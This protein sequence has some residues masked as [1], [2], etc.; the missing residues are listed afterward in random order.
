[1]WDGAG[2]GGSGDLQIKESSQCKCPGV[3]AYLVVWSQPELT[4]LGWSEQEAGENET[5]QD[6]LLSTLFCMFIFFFLFLH[7]LTYE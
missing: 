6:G 4:G 5:R 2:V 1:M 3:A 7:N